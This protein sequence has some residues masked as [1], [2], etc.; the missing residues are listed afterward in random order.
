[1]HRL[2]EQQE[3]RRQPAAPVAASA[4]RT[5]EVATLLGGEGRRLRSPALASLA[6]KVTSAE[7][8]DKVK[9][10]ITQ[11]IARILDESKDEAN[12]KSFC[13]TGVKKGTQERDRYHRETEKLSAELSELE[14][15]KESMK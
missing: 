8:F 13:D 6:L 5:G 14:A 1:M 15:K 3:A 12:K 10:M 4:V 7:P 9:E 11:M 2:V